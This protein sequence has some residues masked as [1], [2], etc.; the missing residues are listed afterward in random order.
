MHAKTLLTGEDNDLQD[1][2]QAHG[3]YANFFKVGHNAFEFLL[4][5]GQSYARRGEAPPHTRI[6]T[7]PVYAKTLARILQEAIDTYEEAFGTIPD[8]NQ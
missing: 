6:V 8:G 7:T 3:Q 4:D 5:F 1:N 2:S